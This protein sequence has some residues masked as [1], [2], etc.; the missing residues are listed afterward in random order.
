MVHKNYACKEHYD[1]SMKMEHL[2][3][4]SLSKVSKSCLTLTP[5]EMSTSE[6]HECQLPHG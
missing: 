3:E 6:G 1:V 5:E 2:Q 4:F